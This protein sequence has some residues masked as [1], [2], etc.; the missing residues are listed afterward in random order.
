MTD[1]KRLRGAII[2]C[3]FFGQ[4]HIEAWRRI[5]QVD[6]VA[7]CDLDEARARAAAPNAYTS[8]EQMLD[9]ERLD[10]VDIVTRADTH[11]PLLRLTVARN[12]AVIC[13]KPIAPTWAEARTMVE[14]AEAAKIPFMVHENWR[15]QPWYRAA[16]DLL[17]RGQIGTPLLYY[18]KTRHRDG[19]GPDPFPCQSYVRDL[20][21]FFIDETLVHHIDTGRYLFGDVNSIFAQARTLNPA[22]RGEDQAILL[23]SHASGLPG[24]VDGHRYLDPDPPG[25]VMGEA[26]I[27]GEL[28]VLRISPTGDLLHEGKLVWRFEP[29]EGYRGDSVGATQRHFI[30][31]LTTGLPFESGGRE[32][33]EKTFSAVEAAYRSLGEKR[34][35]GLSEIVGS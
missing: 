12:L 6:L 28:G 21:R 7:A 2:G 26:F 30:E 18:M 27:D 15:W 1:P 17:S 8:A 3:G 22:V 24:I 29:G 13:Q 9:R 4:R 16:H 11:L 20:E 25:P 5:P 32:Y 19:V 23:L 34:A 31:C 14:I 35:I 10:F 33:L